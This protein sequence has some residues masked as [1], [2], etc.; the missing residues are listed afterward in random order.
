MSDFLDAWA[1]AT[2][3]NA[4]L[5][6]QETF[7]LEVTEEFFRVMEEKGISAPQLVQATVYTERAVNQFLNGNTTAILRMI[8][9]IAFAL[10]V[11]PTFT[12][13]PKEDEPHDDREDYV[14]QENQVCPRCSTVFITKVKFCSSCGADM[15]T[16]GLEKE[17]KEFVQCQI[18]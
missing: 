5:S 12:L 16:G 8:A 6:A 3:E 10:G 9:D 18:K 4:K 2:T 14:V 11:K 15:K 17:L 13:S 7:I 1:E